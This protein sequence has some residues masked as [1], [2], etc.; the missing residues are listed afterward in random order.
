MFVHS[1][2]LGN[3]FVKQNSVNLNK[4]QSACTSD[5]YTF[6]WPSLGAEMMGSSPE[7]TVTLF[8]HCACKPKL[9]LEGRQFGSVMIQKQFP[10]QL[11]GSKQVF[12]K[13]FQQ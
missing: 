3:E 10:L 1:F 11:S 12:G 6:V 9:A 13:H 7:K 4:K 2:A 8:Q 5:Q